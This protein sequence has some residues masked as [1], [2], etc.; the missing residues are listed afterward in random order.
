MDQNI[1][2]NE[3]AIT[4]KCEYPEV[5]ARWADQ[6]Y[7]P[8]ATVQNYWGSFGEC[9]RRESDGSYSLLPL[10]ASFDSLDFRAWNRSPRD[11]G[12][13]FIPENFNKYNLPVD[14]GDGLKLEIAKVGDPY[15]YI[16]EIFPRYAYATP[17]QQREISGLRI[18]IN[19][20]VISTFA[21]WVS[22][23]RVTDTQW[24]S[25]KQRLRAMGLDRY[26]AIQTEIYNAY[27]NR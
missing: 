4:I 16:N 10:Q 2:R 25:Y 15:V 22:A 12:P 7:T 11:S 9:T 23:G 19:N 1:R 21:E 13:G 14:N 3:F 18:D 17:E 5:M 8:D 26:T 20:Y 24:N 6:F 27:N